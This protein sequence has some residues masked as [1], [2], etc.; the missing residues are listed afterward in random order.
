MH[1]S[2]L[3]LWLQAL[4]WGLISGMTLVVGAFLGYYFELPQRFTAAIMSFGAGVLVSVI[5]FDLIPYALTAGLVHTSIG[6]ILG[7]LIYTVA[8]ILVSKRGGGQR[9][10][11]SELQNSETEMAGSGMALAIGALIDGIPESII[12]GMSLIGGTGISIVM[13]I[14]IMISNVPEGLSS[15]V[16]MKKSGRSKSYIFGVWWFIAIISSFFSWVGY[17]F[18]LEL[19]P[20]LMSIATALGAGAML[21]MIADTMIPEASEGSHHSSGLITLLGFLLSLIISKVA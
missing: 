12:L 17:S 6:L 1:L 4:S 18:F 20:E 7:G 10:R 15:S 11:S 14:G 16:G 2:F 19:S 5:C 21:S 8:N 3:P 13:L 9:K